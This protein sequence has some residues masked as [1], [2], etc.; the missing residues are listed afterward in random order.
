MRSFTFTFFVLTIIAGLVG[1]T[2][3]AS[4]IAQFSQSVFLIFIIL[5]IASITFYFIKKTSTAL[6]FS[7]I[8]FAIASIAG[9]LAFTHFTDAMVYIAKM[10]FYV[11]LVLFIISLGIHMTRKRS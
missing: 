3:L 7:L 11:L 1:F 10:S 9:I 5:F 4:M 8:F 2:E 6:S